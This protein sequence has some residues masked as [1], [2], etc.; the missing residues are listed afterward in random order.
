[1][2]FTII[3]SHRGESFNEHMQSMKFEYVHPEFLIHMRCESVE[4]YAQSIV[5]ASTQYDPVELLF[6]L[7]ECVESCEM[8]PLRSSVCDIYFSYKGRG[9][10]WIECDTVSECCDK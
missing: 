8:T 10:G 3:S 7:L 1:M 6:V 5:H 2:E 4:E 9:R